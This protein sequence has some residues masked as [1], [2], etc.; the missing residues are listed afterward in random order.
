V[1]RHPRGVGGHQHLPVVE[2]LRGGDDPGRSPGAHQVRRNLTRELVAH[3]RVGLAAALE[4]GPQQDH[5]PSG[6]VVHQ[7]ERIAR[8]GRVVAARGG[9]QPDAER[10]CCAAQGALLRIV[11][12][13]EDRALRRHGP[14]GAQELQAC[15]RR[16]EA[17]GQRIDRRR[18]AAAGVGVEAQARRFGG[19]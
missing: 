1:E 13:R 15:L 14:H 8:P 5:R 19:S 3:L 4:I 11:D 16:Q 10:A 7:A 9:E 2:R 6:S 18:D 12:E 17:R